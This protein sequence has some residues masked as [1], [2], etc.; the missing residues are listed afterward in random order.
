MASKD[1][2]SRTHNTK[3]DSFIQDYLSDVWG[4]AIAQNK[5]V[6][7]ENTCIDE[8]NT[9]SS[10]D[11]YKASILKGAKS[12]SVKL[13]K[14]IRLTGK[15]ISNHVPGLLFKKS[16]CISSHFS[17]IPTI[18]VVSNSENQLIRTQVETIIILLINFYFLRRPHPPKVRQYILILLE[19]VIDG[20]NAAYL[21][22]GNT[23]KEAYHEV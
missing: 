23:L 2:K 1:D 20:F 22:Q 4:G 6:S 9:A 11:N 14:N 13:Q 18:K 15:I 19:Q 10:P 12:K 7:Q 5:A 8:I 3:M 17:L 21:L 16:G